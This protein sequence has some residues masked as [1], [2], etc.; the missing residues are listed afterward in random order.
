M[1]AAQNDGPSHG[2]VILGLAPLYTNVQPLL[3][4]Q[5]LHGLPTMPPAPASLGA[6]LRDRSS[7][8][9]K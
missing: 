2:A 7:R 5:R 9:E 8:A 4:Q 6:V 3:G 1:P